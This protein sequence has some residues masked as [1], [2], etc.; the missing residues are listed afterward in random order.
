M[1]K[2]DRVGFVVFLIWFWIIR[3]LYILQ[4][5]S[6]AHKSENICS[7]F[8]WTVRTNSRKWRPWSSVQLCKRKEIEGKGKLG[9]GI[10]SILGTTSRVGS[11]SNSGYPMSHSPINIP[12]CGAPG[13]MWSPEFFSPFFSVTGVEVNQYVETDSPLWQ[14]SLT[15][16]H[17]L[18]QSMGETQFC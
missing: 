4:K 16:L 11:S 9:T 15:L 12:P 1:T 18:S 13:E 10:M 8:S 6:L 7:F 2:K 14:D 5:I 3:K 17:L